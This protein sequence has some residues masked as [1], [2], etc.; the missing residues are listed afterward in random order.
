MKIKRILAGILDLYRKMFIKYFHIIVI[1]FSLYFLAIGFFSLYLPEKRET[2]KLKIEVQQVK[3][4]CLDIGHE[5]QRKLLLPLREVSS[6][7]QILTNLPTE[8]RTLA[9]ELAEFGRYSISKGDYQIA[10]EKLDQSLGIAISPEA[11]YYKGIAFFN[12]EDFLTAVETWRKILKIK[13]NQEFKR[14]VVLYIGMACYQMNDYKRANHYFR[15]F[16]EE[17]EL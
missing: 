17:L 10:L 3:R 2:E 11:L 13:T 7:S 12:K 6:G 4:E 15:V 16:I 14:N 8:Q 9:K 1:A 5:M